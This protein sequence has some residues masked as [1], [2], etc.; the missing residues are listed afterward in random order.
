MA[1]A[2]IIL[3][4]DLHLGVRNDS[5]VFAENQLQFMDELISYATANKIDTI[6]Q[7]GDVFDRRKYTNHAVVDL[8]KSRFF[9][10]LEAAGISFHM[11][12]GNHDVMYKNT[13][14]V[15]APKIFLSGYK[16]ITIYDEPTEVT[17]KDK[18]FLVL[19][20]ICLD[21]QAR[22]IELMQDSRV[23][24]VFGHLELAGFEMYKGQVSHDGMDKEVLRRFDKVFTGHFHTISAAGNVH[25]LGCP[26]ELTWADHAD[27]RGFHV[28]D[29]STL[30]TKFIQNQNNMF[31]RIE[32]DDDGKG[33]DY[34]KGF[35]VNRYAG[36]YLKLVVVNKTDTSQF[37]R[38]VDSLHHAGLE[39]FKI[40]QNMVDLT[41]DAI[42]DADVD[43]ESSIGLIESYVDAAD[44]TVD[45][46]KLKG[47][48]KTLY[49]SA[50]EV[51]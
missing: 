33:D 49:V 25:Y 36:K 51:I 17:L 40:I 8:W 20:W 22:S 15:N 34:W 41:A 13:L 45:K 47:L 24:C 19:P 11:L 9:D 35:D 37:D 14:S 6:F 3:L 4:G 7:F 5:L 30:K 2:K 38:L 32:Y 44:V 18:K 10:K 12:L 29:V 43:F 46:D 16:N 42:D 27:P 28:L 50:L 31:H 1:K 48:M 23:E 26:F 21:N 39:D